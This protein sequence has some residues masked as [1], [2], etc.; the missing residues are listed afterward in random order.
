M[1]HL[2]IIALLLA[3]TGCGHNVAVSSKGIGIRLAWQPDSVSPELNIGYFEVSAGV[4]R[5]NATFLFESVNALNA[6]NGDARSVTSLSTGEQA[7]GY[8]TRANGSVE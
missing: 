4:I 6:E 7:N 1:K 2:V 8:S 5:E 3:A